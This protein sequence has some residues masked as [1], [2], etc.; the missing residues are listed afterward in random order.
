MEI[1][2]YSFG[3]VVINGKVYE[4]DLII[5]PRRIKEN[6]WRK[7]GHELNPEDIK[8]VLK[9]KPKMLI[10]GTGAYGLLKVKEETKK[11]LERNNIK[12]LELET[13]KA[14]EFYNKLKDKNGVILALHLTC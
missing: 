8:E 5:F 7:E 14:C 1:E 13:K 4:K 3:R 11:I 12:L 10:V 6:W 9:E 2:S